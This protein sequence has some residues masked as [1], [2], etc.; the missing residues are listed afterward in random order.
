MTKVDHHYLSKAIFNTIAVLLLGFFLSFFLRVI[1][2]RDLG[3]SLFGEYA[4]A[5][6]YISLCTTFIMLGLVRLPVRFLPGYFDNKLYHDASGFFRYSSQSILLRALVLFVFAMCIVFIN[7]IW[8]TG[9]LSEVD[10]WSNYVMFATCLLCS[11][12]MACTMYLSSLLQA[13]HRP[14]LSVALNRLLRNALFSSG[15]ILFIFIFGRVGLTSIFTVLLA[16]IAF[17][18]AIQLVLLYRMIPSKF[19]SSKPRYHKKK[20]NSEA[21]K[22][23]FVTAS[24]Q[25]FTSV[26]L[27]LFEYLS[28]SEAAVGV[29]AS[30]FI[31]VAIINT[32]GTALQTVFSPQISKYFMN[33]DYGK[34]QSVVNIANVCLVIS[35]AII[36]LLVIYFSNE[37]LTLFGR[38]FLVGTRALLILTIGSAILAC[39]RVAFMLLG[40]TDNQP[41]L[42]KTFLLGILVLIVGSV[43][44]IPTYGLVG[45]VISNLIAKFFQQ[46]W[47]IIAVRKRLQIK[48]LG[49]L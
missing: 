49:F 6:R 19:Y 7:Y 2:A 25:L 43:L 46:G 28:K 34:L 18:I 26:D 8:P 16:V 9:I 20:W 5:F 44:L 40:Y 47:R 14:V 4:V 1:I 17:Q 38:S 29:F 41:F 15:I 31:I 22:F 36:S 33:K 27:F 32:T 24:L 10:F 48:P 21:I 42:I 37:I 13:L 35:V 39:G 3:A 11:L 12:G 45:G 30:L 23:F